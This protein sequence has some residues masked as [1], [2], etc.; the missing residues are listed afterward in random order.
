MTLAAKGRSVGN[1]AQMIAQLSSIADQM[2]A[3]TL[4]HGGSSLSTASRSVHMR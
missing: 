4:S 3:P 2:A 1:E